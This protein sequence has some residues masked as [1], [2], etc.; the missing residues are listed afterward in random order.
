MNKRNEQ[1]LSRRRKLKKCNTHANCLTNWLE[2]FGGESAF[3]FSDS[4]ELMRNF[5]ND[6]CK[7]NS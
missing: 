5:I 3:A 4:S 2:A 7:I 1:H 6:A